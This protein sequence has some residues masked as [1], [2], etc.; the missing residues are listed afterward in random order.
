VLR[1]YGPGVATPERK[2]YISFGQLAVDVLNRGLRGFLSKWHPLLQEHE[3][4]RPAGVS[5]VEH[6]RKWARHDELR[7]E[8]DEKR[9]QLTQYADIL[10]EICDVPRLHSD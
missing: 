2:K 3:A 9:Q 1:H 5:T 7:K 8:L 4:T 6:E 10:A